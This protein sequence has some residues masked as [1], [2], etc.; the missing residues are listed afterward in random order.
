MENTDKAHRARI[1]NL[2]NIADTSQ[3]NKTRILENV[4]VSFRIDENEQKDREIVEKGKKKEKND[5]FFSK[6]DEPLSRW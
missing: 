2:S 1:V 4:F 5:E 3:K 6:A